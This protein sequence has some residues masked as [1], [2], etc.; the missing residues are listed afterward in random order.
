MSDARGLL[1][2]E[3][4]I[5]Y[6]TMQANGDFIAYELSGNKWQPLN[7]PVCKVRIR[8]YANS[9]HLLTFS[10]QAAAPWYTEDP[11]S[12]PLVKKQLYCTRCNQ[13]IQLSQTKVLRGQ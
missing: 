12:T 3:N 4:E 2:L 1:L 13:P 11:L 5:P 10:P 7:C 8:F 6:I 9:S